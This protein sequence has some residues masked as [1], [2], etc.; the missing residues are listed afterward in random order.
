VKH[1]LGWVGTKLGAP[2]GF[3][4]ARKSLL[5]TWRDAVCDSDLSWRAVGVAL[6]LSTF[7]NA[8]AEAWPSRETIARRMKRSVRTV[9]AGLAELEVHGFLRIWHS[10]G[11]KSKPNRYLAQLPET[12]QEK[13]RIEWET[14]QQTT[15]NGAAQVANGA[16]PA[17]ESSYESGRES[18][19]VER[20]S[21]PP[22]IREECSGCGKIRDLVHDDTF[23]ADC[24]P[25]GEGVSDP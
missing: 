21:R 10:R 6:V 7:M 13:R 2:P 1:G 19:E 22:L 15:A 3:V 12:V 23:C 18:G 16:R 8:Q 17:H 20:G 11:G 14:V 5:G 25:P 9:D 24:W 4:T